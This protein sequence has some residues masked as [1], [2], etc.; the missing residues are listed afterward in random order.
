MAE[1][2]IKQRVGIWSVR[3]RGVL[4]RSGELEVC[5]EVGTDMQRVFPVSPG[6]RSRVLWFREGCWVGRPG[7]PESSRAERP[8]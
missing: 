6:G 3:G 4:G 5:K 7:G 1:E 2:G 8:G